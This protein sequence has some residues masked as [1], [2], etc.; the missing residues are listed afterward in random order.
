MINQ[1]HYQP[2]II[3]LIFKQLNSIINLINHYIFLK[4]IF[5]LNNVSYNF[6]LNI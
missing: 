5:T 1:F 2:L 3:K 6:N 4:M